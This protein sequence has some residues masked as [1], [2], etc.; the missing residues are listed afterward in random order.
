MTHDN[1]LSS[2]VLDATPVSQKPLSDSVKV[3]GQNELQERGT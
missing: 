3:T 2:G 1:R